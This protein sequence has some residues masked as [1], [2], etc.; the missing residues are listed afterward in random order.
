MREIELNTCPPSSDSSVPA[1]RDPTFDEPQDQMVDVLLQ[2]ADPMKDEDADYDEL[3][4]EMG[5]GKYQ[6]AVCLICMFCNAT[7]AIEIM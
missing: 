6:W 3:V 7:D 1:Q 5:V 4:A 2:H